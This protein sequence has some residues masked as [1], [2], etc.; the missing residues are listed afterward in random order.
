MF[1]WKLL[2]DYSFNVIAVRKHANK[3]LCFC[4]LKLFVLI[5]KNNVLHVSVYVKHEYDAK[6]EQL[7]AEV[8]TCKS[9]RIISGSVV[10]FGFGFCVRFN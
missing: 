9:R 4:T 10:F 5:G 1:F 6:L 2:Q 3:K 7:Q 8:N